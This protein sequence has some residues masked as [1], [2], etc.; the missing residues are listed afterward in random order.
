MIFNSFHL[1]SV[2]LL[3]HVSISMRH[4]IRRWKRRFR[5]WTSRISP[6][7]KVLQGTTSLRLSDTLNLK[8]KRAPYTL[9]VLILPVKEAYRS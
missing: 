6:C 2:P 9:H 4:F 7:P 3:K 8:T 5:I 1:Q